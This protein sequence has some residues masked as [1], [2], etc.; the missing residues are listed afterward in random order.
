MHLDRLAGS[1]A[2]QVANIAILFVKA[3][4]AMDRSHFVESGIDRAM[5]LSNRQALHTEADERS[6][7]GLS[8]FN[9]R[10]V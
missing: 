4:E 3:H 10:I 6:H 1:G 9:D 5:R 7:P 8:T 2:I